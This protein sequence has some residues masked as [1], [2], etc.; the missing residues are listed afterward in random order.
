MGL[1]KSA[2]LALLF[3]G[4]KKRSDVDI[5]VEFNELPDVFNLLIWRDY[6]KTSKK[7]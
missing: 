2:F 5:L 3:E 6:L 7:S 1:R 4:T